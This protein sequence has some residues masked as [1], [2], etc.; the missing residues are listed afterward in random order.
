MG[1]DDGDRGREGE[2]SS[3]PHHGV[4]RPVS[5]RFSSA[6]GAQLGQ[7]SG[8][9]NIESRG[10]NRESHSSLIMMLLQLCTEIGWDAS[11]IIRHCNQI[12]EVFEVLIATTGYKS[13]CV[14][15]PFLR[16]RTIL[17][18]ID[19]EIRSAIAGRLS[20]MFNSNV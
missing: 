17:N 13:T 14:K 10:E 2:S 12:S 7:R 9:G 8:A 16:E 6:F 4:T 19:I 11:E 20:L 15:M 5:Q 3:S 1:R 18:D